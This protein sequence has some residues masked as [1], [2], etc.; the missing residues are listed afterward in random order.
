M[1]ILGII[2][3]LSILIIGY[4]F[5]KSI[6]HEKFES[7]YFKSVLYVVCTII[8]ASIFLFILTWV[9]VVDDWAA[10]PEYDVQSKEY[11]L[12]SFGDGNYYLNQ[13]KSN[14]IENIS[15][16]IKNNDHYEFE[17]CYSVDNSLIILIDTIKFCNTNKI[18]RVII[19]KRANINI[20][21]PQ[22]LF[23]KKKNWRKRQLHYDIYKIEF[24]IPENSIN[25]SL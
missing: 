23:I 6:I 2:T 5:Y 22:K 9:T 4:W 12:I 25:K 18:P 17:T 11:E 13:F 3:I 15:Y 16:I 19:Y 7:F 24:R 8:V 21:L 1:S 14:N 10:P 20:R